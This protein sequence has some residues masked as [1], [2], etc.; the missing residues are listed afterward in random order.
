VPQP[1]HYPDPRQ[2]IVANRE[3]A[4]LEQ[5]GKDQSRL[6]ALRESYQFAGDETC[7]TCGLCESACPVGINTGALTSQ[8]R[9]QI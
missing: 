2:R 9:Q 7:T 5:S 3:M 1:R 4:A 6:D 8:L